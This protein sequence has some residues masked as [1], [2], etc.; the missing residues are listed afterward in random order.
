MDSFRGPVLLEVA[1]YLK[2]RIAHS[3]GQTLEDFEIDKDLAVEVLLAASYLQI[4]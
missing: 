4:E 2:Y 3:Q 1:R